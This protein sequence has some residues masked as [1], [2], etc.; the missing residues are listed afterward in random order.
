MRLFTCWRTQRLI[1]LDVEGLLPADQRERLVAHLAC[2][3]RCRETHGQLL[4][5]QELVCEVFASL[6]RPMPPGF[7]GRLR[8]EYARRRV[9][10][11]R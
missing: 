9:V 3:P 2:C 1:D 4:E 7:A 6:D 5:L 10:A 11:D 8:R